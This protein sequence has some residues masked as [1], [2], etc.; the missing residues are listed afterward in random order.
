MITGGCIMS[1]DSFVIP[2]D[3]VGQLHKA[4]AHANLVLEQ[5][6]ELRDE[7]RERLQAARANARDRFDDRRIVDLEEQIRLLENGAHF[8]ND[9][10]DADVS[11]LIGSQCVQQ[12][13]LMRPGIM[14]ITRQVRIWTAKL[15][16]IETEPA[17]RA[18]EMRAAAELYAQRE[19]KTAR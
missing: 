5:I 15:H 12:L 7:Y 9:G 4:I 17:R 18:D 8:R 14:S 6:T 2:T 11:A 3:S 19:D 13:G 10:L 1:L 16:E